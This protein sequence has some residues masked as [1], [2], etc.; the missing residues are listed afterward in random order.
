MSNN[1]TETEKKLP[2]V[3]DETVQEAKEM[4]SAQMVEFTTKLNGVIL[5]QAELQNNF[6]R[7]YLSVFERMAELEAFGGNDMLEV[8]GDVGG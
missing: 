5:C 8:L 2:E 7:V 3:G 4:D 1:K 6:E